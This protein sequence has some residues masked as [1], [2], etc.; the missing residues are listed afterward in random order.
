[1]IPSTA[2]PCSMQI[3]TPT[4]RKYGLISSGSPTYCPVT[5]CGDAI[6]HRPEMVEGPVSRRWRDRTQIRDRLLDE[7]THTAD[8]V[9]HSRRAPRTVPRRPI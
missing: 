6:G 5:G 3:S 1:M 2:T 8:P 7:A 9:A 4:T